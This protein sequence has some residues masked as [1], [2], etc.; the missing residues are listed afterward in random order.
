MIPARLEPLLRPDGVPV[1]LARRFATAGK[2][3]FLVG[4][5]VRDALLG[6]APAHTDLDFATPCRPAETRRVVAGWA[7]EVY[8]IGEAFGT[9][10]VLKD[11]VKVEITTFRAEVYRGDSRKPVVQYSEDLETDLSR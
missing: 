7:D 8:T 11:G 3:L 10:G 2:E 1:A 5:S 6:R 9:V 4:G